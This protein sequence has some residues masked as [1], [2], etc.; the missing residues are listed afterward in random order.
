MDERHP[1]DPADVAG[2]RCPACGFAVVLDDEV[3]LGEVIWC[4]AC[5]AELEV[6]SLE[7][8]VLALFEEEEK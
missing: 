4:T 6:V 3:V 7:P 8:V 1:A 2:T 5:G